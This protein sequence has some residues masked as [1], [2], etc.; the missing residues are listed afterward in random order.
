MNYRVRARV[1]SSVIVPPAAEDRIGERERSFQISALGGEVGR[2]RFQISCSRPL[3]NNYP[4]LAAE[5]GRI[6]F[7]T[8]AS[9]AK[10]TFGTSFAAE[11]GRISFQISFSHPLPNISSL[12]ADFIFASFDRSREKN[13]RPIERERAVR[14]GVFRPPARSSAQVAN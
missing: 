10:H 11:V 3:S 6:R 12:V 7:Q 2:N 4:P 5:V 14:S 9:F 8:R 1:F 13:M